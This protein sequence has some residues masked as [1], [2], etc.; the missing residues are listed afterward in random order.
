MFEKLLL[1]ASWLIFLGYGLACF[2][3][4]ELP[5]ALA[6]LSIESGDGFAEMGAMYGGLQFG[7]G[8]FCLMCAAIPVHTRAGLLLLLLGIGCIALARLVSAWDA[9]W[10]V[11]SYTWGALAFELLVSVLAAVALKR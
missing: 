3:N 8:V 9:D 1:S 10:M 5:A 4:P 11:G 7:V 6:G 2:I